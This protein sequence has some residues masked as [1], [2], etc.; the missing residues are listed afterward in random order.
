MDPITREAL[1]IAATQVGVR[2]Q[3]PGSNRGPQVEAYLRR[4]G[5]YPG[6]AWCAAFVYWCFDEAADK[7]AGVNRLPRTGYCPD[8]EA[9]GKAHGLLDQEPQV[10]DVFLV[11]R[12]PSGEK[13]VRACHTGIVTGVSA[14][15]IETVE[16]N[17]NLG[18]GSEGIGV[19]ARTRAR[20]A[21]L[22]FVHATRVLAPAS[23]TAK[24]TL[25]GSLLPWM[26]V[27]EGGHSSV[28]V[29]ALAEKLGKTVT[30]DGDDQVVLLDGQPLLAHLTMV[31]QDKAYH[32]YAPTLELAKALNLTVSYDA[33]HNTIGLRHGS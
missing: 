5:R 30:W 15:A 22:R 17:T 19:F 8:L 29:R 9:W 4:V 25:N 7:V 14:G 31:L 24:V 11:R 20:S 27:V 21:Q 16:G 10:G 33:A 26:A 2:E 1:A 28:P 13:R 12:V 32:A 23:S 3:P 6:E 18:G